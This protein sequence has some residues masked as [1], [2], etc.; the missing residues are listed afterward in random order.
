[1]RNIGY[2][3]TRE[4]LPTWFHEIA[5]LITNLGNYSTV[6]GLS[7]L[8]WF[9]LKRDTNFFP[10]IAIL[11]TIGIVTILKT[12]FGLPRPP[13]AMISGYGFPSGHATVSV[14]FFGTLVLILR[15]DL[16]ARSV[17]FT[18]ASLILMIGL[19]RIAMGVHYPI[20]VLVGFLLG[21]LILW[22][23]REVLG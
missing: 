7:V 19:S 8:I 2:D 17:E 18:G 11:A 6:F 14:V 23:V 22:R 10:V 4:I 13:E 5:P 20:D 21:G 16:H 3:F 12:I 1:M 15:D 9:V